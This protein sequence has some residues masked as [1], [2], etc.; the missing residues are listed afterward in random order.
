MS[1]LSRPL[2]TDYSLLTTHYSLLTTHCLL[3]TAHYSL[4]TTH[5]SLLTTHCSLLT[6]HY[7]LLTTRY[8]LLTPLRML[9]LN[10]DAYESGNELALS[11]IGSTT[12]NLGNKAIQLADLVISVIIVHCLTLTLTLN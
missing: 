8:L 7:L 10:S 9:L 12:D 11:I 5:Y 2:T 6:T 3:L 4:L 1:R